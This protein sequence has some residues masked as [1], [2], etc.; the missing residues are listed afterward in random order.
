MS[1]ARL[2]VGKKLRSCMWGSTRVGAIQWGL[3]TD[4]FNL[5]SADVCGRLHSQG[6]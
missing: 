5:P 3:N 2:A 6:Q 4:G 1:F